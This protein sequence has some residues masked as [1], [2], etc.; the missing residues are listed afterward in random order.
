MDRSLN[1]KSIFGKAGA[2]KRAAIFLDR[3]GV[4]IKDKHYIKNPEGVEL[5]EGICSIIRRANA[6]MWKVVVI[7]NQSGIGRGYFGW[8]EYEAVTDRMIS[9]L[10]EEEAFIDGVY[11]CGQEPGQSESEWRKPAPGMIIEAARDLNIEKSSS[12][13]I[14]D[15]LSD[16]QAGVNAGI[17]RCFHVNERNSSGYRESVVTWASINRE[18]N[19][20]S[21]ISV[22]LLESP[23]DFP[24]EEIRF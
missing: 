18:A 13:I 9:L 15:R 7:T 3:D 21:K 19:L 8:T 23:D 17:R 1:K 24:L 6:M 22:R 20:K 5:R 12:I 11:A 14:G 4:V 16:L 2:S 10:K